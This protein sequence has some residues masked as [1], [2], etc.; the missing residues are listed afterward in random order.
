MSRLGQSSVPGTLPSASPMPSTTLPMICG[1]PF[2]RATDPVVGKELTISSSLNWKNEPKNWLQKCDF[3]QRAT[4]LT[5]VNR[6]FAFFFLFS[7]ML[8][9]KAISGYINLCLQEL[10]MVRWKRASNLWTCRSYLHRAST[11]IHCICLYLSI[12]YL[13]L[14]SPPLSACLWIS[15]VYLSLCTN[16]YL[17]HPLVSSI[18]LSISVSF[19]VSV[20]IYRGLS[21][22]IYLSIY[23]YIYTPIIYPSP[24]I[25]LFD[26]AYL[27]Q[28]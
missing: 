16:L 28:S 22:C 1:P 21:Y 25:Y 5:I 24:C 20:S 14:S 27:D 4:W 10:L 19:P 7:G 13:S 18:Y 2:L 17:Y 8:N 23:L 6:F 9:C 12:F 26:F 3:W 11:S 15:M